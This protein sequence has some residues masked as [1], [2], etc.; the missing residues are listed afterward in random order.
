MPDAF[1]DDLEGQT[2]AATIARDDGVDLFEDDADSHK[3][4]DEFTDDENDNVFGRGDGDDEEAISL[5]N[6][7]RGSR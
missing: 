6:H 1:S 5:H 2:A 7:R 3:Y 4:R